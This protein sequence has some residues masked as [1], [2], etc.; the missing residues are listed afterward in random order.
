MESDEKY[1]E[2]KFGRQ[3]HF[4]VP[5][6]YLQNLTASVMANVGKQSECDASE[7][8]TALTENVTANTRDLLMQPWWRRTRVRI[9]A[10]VACLLLAGGTAF[11]TYS[12]HHA[13]PAYNIAVSAPSHNVEADVSTSYNEIADYTMLDND[14]IYSLLASN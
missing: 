5:E 1:L 4:A 8:E 2:R 14:D 6:G 12:V 3:N 11:Y 13:E 7:N 10:A 9:A